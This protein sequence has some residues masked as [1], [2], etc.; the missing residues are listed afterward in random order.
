AT[1]EH[2]LGQQKDPHAEMGSLVLLR[3]I[4]K[5]MGQ[6]GRTLSQCTPPAG[7]RHM[8]LPSPW[9]SAQSCPWVVGQRS[10][11]PDPWRPTGWGQ[12]LLHSVTTRGSRQVG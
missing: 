4:V 7:H 9:A 6:G 2:D 8:P 1:K 5:V 10:A 12:R 11:I 3:D